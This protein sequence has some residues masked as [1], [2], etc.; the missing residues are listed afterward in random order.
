MGVAWLHLSL[1]LLFLDIPI[2][3]LVEN[4]E[5]LKDVVYYG[6]NSNKKEYN[7]ESLLRDDE[8]SNLEFKKSAFL[9]K[10][11]KHGSNITHDLERNVVGMLNG[12]VDAYS[13]R[14]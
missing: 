1:F 7:L 9:V 14:N 2:M 12:V 10:M 8:N 5:E 4:P 3:H 13:Y 11:K 6:P